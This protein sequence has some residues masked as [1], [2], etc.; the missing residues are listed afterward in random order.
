MLFRG[1]FQLSLEGSFHLAPRN[2]AQAVGKHL[3][4]QLLMSFPFPIFIC[5]EFELCFLIIYHIKKI[6][7]MLIVSMLYFQFHTLS[8]VNVH[9]EKEK[10]V[11]ENFK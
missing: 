4:M 6:N 1:I 5:F 8:T 10:K 11:L 7:F 9:I 2:L 3:Q